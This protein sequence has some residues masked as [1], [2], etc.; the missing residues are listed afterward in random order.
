MKRIAIV[1]TLLALSG[2]SFITS[3]INPAKFDQGEYSAIVDIRQILSH[4][5]LCKDSQLGLS[6]TLQY[7][8]EWASK[9]SEF[10]PS[11]NDSFKMF[12]VLK[13]EA[14]KFVEISATK[15]NP[16]YCKDKLEIMEN[17]AKLIQRTLAKKVR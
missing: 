3:L 13:E 11:N 10:L 4:P 7:K 2:C 16:V 1:V 15:T 14:D 5:E 17:Q 9:Y 12:T 8:V 6:Q